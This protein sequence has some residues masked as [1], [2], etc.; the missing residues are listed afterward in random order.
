MKFSPRFVFLFALFLVWKAFAVPP[1]GYYEVWGDEFNGSSLDP[2]KWWVWNQQDRSGYSTPSAVTVTN[3][4]MTIQVYST[5]GQNYSGIVSSDGRFRARYGYMEASVEF[6]GSP[7]MFSDFW[8]NS[9]DNGAFIGDPAAEGA[10]VDVCE[11]R[12]T[13]ANNKD[14][15][16]GN[17]TIDLHWNGY[18]SSE[19][20]FNS[21]FYGSGLGTGFHTYGLLWTTNNYQ[22][23]ID[24]VL[25]LTTNGGLSRRTEIVL[26]SCEVDSNSFCGIVPTGGYGNANV[27]TTST[28][29]D[30]F[31]FYAPTTTVYWLG[32]SSA[33]WTDSGNWLSNMVPTAASDV[34]FSFLTVGNPSVNLSPGTTVN[35]LSIQEP[36]AITLSGGSLTVGGGGIDLL[37]AVNNTQ[38]NSPL[39]LGANQS[40]SIAAGITLNIGSV[41]TGNA[42][43]T[44][45]QFGAVAIYGTNNST[46][47]TFVNNGSLLDYGVINN[48]TVVGGGSVG[49]TG[50]FAGPVT[51]NAGLLT[52]T[53]TFTAPVV[54]NA[55]H[56]G[57]GQY[58]THKSE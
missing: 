58:H 32:A 38:M 9:A 25:T 34:V 55:G 41:V 51:V 33:N 45:D 37:S 42:D 47:S 8:I 26:F 2:T 40:W 35:S 46:G 5:N 48:S 17:V 10:E 1:S 22:A 27:S 11:H 53:E 4:Y 24:G 30:Y 16:S 18:G 44:Q 3:G 43:V 7:G 49:G 15:I 39:A 12:V 36:N 56:P 31:R 57:S 29:V 6:N 23:S 19:T 21:P 28:V 50:L 13:D 20:S 52:G 54:I 14:N